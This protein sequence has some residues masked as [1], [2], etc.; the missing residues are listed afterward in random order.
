MMP[1]ASKPSAA[2][3]SKPRRASPSP[4]PSPGTA[5]RTA[6]NG[7]GQ[8]RRSPLSDLNS[9]DAS[10]ARGGCFRFFV[11][12]ASGSRSRCAS[13]TR[14]PLES[15]KAK[16]R[17]EVGRGRRVADQES[18]TRVEKMPRG[19][20][21]GSGGG[22]GGQI[23]TE[24]ARKQGPPARGQQQ[25]QQVL[26]HVE[27]L[28]PQR[29]ADAGATPASGAT[30]PIHASISPEVLACGSATPACFAAGHHVVPGV[31]DRR[32][33]RPRG[34]L[35]IA[36]EGASEELD[37]DPS[38]ASI[39]WLSSPS[40]DGAGTCSTK[41]AN[42]ASV[43]WLP[44]PR[45]ERG[46][47]LLG[48]DIFVPRCSLEDAFWQLSPNSTGLLSSPVLGGLLDFGTPAS[49]L[50]E[51]TPSSGFLLVQKTPSTGDSISPFSLIVKRASQ[52]LSS[53]G[54][55]S[56]CSQQGLGSCSYGSAADPTAIS[57]DSWNS[58]CSGLTRT[59]SRPLTKM[60]PVVE[61]LEMM[62]LSPRPGDADYCENGALPAPPLPELSFQFAGAP[63][64]LE[65]IDLTSFKRSPCG[66]E[67]KEKNASLQ[68]PALVET[69]ISWREGLVSRMFDVGD[70][71]CC[72]WWSDDED[73]PVFQGN[74]E[75]LRD[76]K[77]QPVSPSCL[78]ACGDQLAA[79]GFGSVE[80]DYSGG[81]TYD[82]SKPS[83]NLI[84]VAE[85]M[86]AE[87]FELVS[88]DDSDW[89]LFYKNGLF[90]T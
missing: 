22:G 29:K 11:S 18:R 51:T 74:D 61:C 69:R 66:I 21:E 75:A 42:E 36:G 13:A 4:S 32:K 79:C 59:C 46:V 80:F 17:V 54:M 78:Q 73:G 82:G 24:T 63:M 40:G 48:D 6:K 71:D 38:R 16:P 7:G 33:C 34:I 52:S 35:A 60:D 5:P 72:K 50:L 2:S 87:G 53:R 62:T 12:S 67:F 57:G 15:P 90:E 70:L 58:K 44:S 28:T 14:T 76:T 84:S 39:H 30:P 27:V 10:A 83:P 85:S 81:K 68:K 89:T 86:R 88:S 77:L 23:R 55:K 41:C 1:R 8:R 3:A 56:L 45:E 37:A 49:E 9:G 47:D 65:S 25:Q 31:G 64:P 20:K 19:K 26:P 43:N